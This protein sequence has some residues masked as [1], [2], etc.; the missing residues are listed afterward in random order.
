MHVH[1]YA[2]R[3]RGEKV[4]GPEGRREHPEFMTS[5][6]VPLVLRDWLVRPASVISATVESPDEAAEWHARWIKEFP[7][8]E[9]WWG[10]YTKE[11]AV[12]ATSRRML[13]RGDKIDGFYTPGGEFVAATFIPCPTLCGKYPCPL[14]RTDGTEWGR[15]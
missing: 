13:A 1:I 7:R 3:H 8:P 5:N 10:L 11:Q 12:A 14:G 9:S 4:S 15:E 2:T 6:V